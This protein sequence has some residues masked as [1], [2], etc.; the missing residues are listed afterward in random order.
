MVYNYLNKKGS[1][2]DIIQVLSLS[3]LPYWRNE[4]ILW[5]G[6]SIYR[7]IASLFTLNASYIQTTNSPPYLY[8]RNF[9]LIYYIDFCQY[10]HEKKTK[11]IL[12][13]TD[14]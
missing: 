9:D 14:N 1:R 7:D 12:P 4:S 2:E 6:Q 10:S 8:E 3:P 11:N 13:H 5:K